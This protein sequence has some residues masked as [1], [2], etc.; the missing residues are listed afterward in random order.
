[1]SASTDRRQQVRGPAEEA[2][3]E[4]AR[5]TGTLGKA[6]DVLEVIASSPAPL[7]F[8]DLLPLTG[9][10]RGTLHRQLRNLIDEG[11]LSVGRDQT[12]ELGFRLLRFASRSGSRNRF[13]EIA[14]PVMRRLHEATGE[15]VHL[16]VLSGAEV[17]YLD[18]VESRQTVRMHSQIG[19]ASPTYCTGVGKAALSTLDDAAVRKLLEKTDFKRHT[20]TTL[21]GIDAL[22][23]ELHDI[24]AEGNAYDRE[25]HEPGIHCVAAPVSSREGTLAAGV[26]VTAPA[27][28][29]PMRQLQAWA[30][31]V[32]EAGQA[33]SEEVNARLSPRN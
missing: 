18:K 27:F 9:Q 33:L 11:L 7:R 29:V 19:N 15:T 10:P 3:Q 31:L 30:P 12:Y 2:G 20:P 1:M 23:A 28:R 25:E 16:G 5:D 6:M 14:E 22:I 26:S 24:R 21:A 13:R 17:V 4:A 32:R 8:T